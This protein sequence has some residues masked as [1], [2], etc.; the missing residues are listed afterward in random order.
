MSLKLDFRPIGPKGQWGFFCHT[1]ASHNLLVP[2]FI[3]ARKSG[4]DPD[5]GIFDGPGFFTVF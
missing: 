5:S 4:R 2:S 1:P 3:R